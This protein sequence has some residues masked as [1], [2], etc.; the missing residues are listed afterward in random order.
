[1]T[2]PEIPKGPAPTISAD[3]MMP[4]TDL[5]RE[6]R[7][8]IDTIIGYLDLLREDAKENGQE[9]MSPELEQIWM[10]SIELAALVEKN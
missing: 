9:S 8:Y 5:K 7:T 6:V 10:A 4:T 2:N 1:M 3:S